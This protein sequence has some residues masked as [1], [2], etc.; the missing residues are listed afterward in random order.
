[1]IYP[2]KRL[3]KKINRWFF[4][5]FSRLSI[6]WKNYSK[7]SEV[8]LTNIQKKVLEITISSIQDLDSEL[9]INPMIDN[10]IG[11]KYYVKKYNSENEVEKFITISKMTSG[12]S[13]ALVGHEIIDN[14][15]HSYH[16]DIWFSERFC[17]F[18]VDKF[19]RN[20]KRR[21][22]KMEIDIRRDDEK[23][24]ALI[25]KKSKNS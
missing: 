8:E 24:L 7:N 18:L 3:F 1:M 22:D 11:E 20:L 13:V 14:V 21:R 15:K 12:C 17:I 2:V 6:K 19:K 5:R 23:T 16:F 10:E 9:L 4:Y 25:L